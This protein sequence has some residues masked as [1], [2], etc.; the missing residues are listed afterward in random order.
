MEPQKNNFRVANQF[1]DAPLNP[2]SPELLNKEG[3]STTCG[4][5]DVDLKTTVERSHVVD[6]AAKLG[7]PLA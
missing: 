6:T 4:G 5:S 1:R 7:E 3:W 2:A